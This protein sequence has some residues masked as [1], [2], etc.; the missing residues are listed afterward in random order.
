MSLIIPAVELLSIFLFFIKESET[1]LP[2]H[3]TFLKHFPVLNF[4]LHSLHPHNFLGQ[5]SFTA[6][7]PCECQ[8]TISCG[9]KAALAGNSHK[10]AASLPFQ[11]WVLGQQSFPENRVSSLQ[12]RVEC[13]RANPPRA[14]I[15]LLLVCV[16]H[17]MFMN[18]QSKFDKKKKFCFS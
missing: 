12:I 2:L 4:F 5:A 10:A 15:S 16:L 3:T 1:N 17:L 11:L 14:Y 6:L 9:L 8:V 18:Y 7:S 13:A